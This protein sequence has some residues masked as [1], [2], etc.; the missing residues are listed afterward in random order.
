MTIV[1]DSQLYIYI[2]AKN[3]LNLKLIQCISSHLVIW[4]TFL[5]FQC[6]N[7]QSKKMYWKL[8]KFI[9]ICPL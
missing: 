2:R 8:I 4:S 6:F 3:I 7:H 1:T 5:F 9:W